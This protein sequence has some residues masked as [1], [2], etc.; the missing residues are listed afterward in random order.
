MRK[1]IGGGL[2]VSEG[3]Y[4]KPGAFSWR[5][6]FTP[7]LTLR[8]LHKLALLLSLVSCLL[9]SAYAQDTGGVKGRVRS[10]RGDTIAGATVTARRDSKEIRTAT[11]DQKGE[12][13]LTGLDP[14]TYNFAFDAKGYATGVKYGVEIKKGKIKDLGDRLYLQVDQGT[15]V[16]VRGSVF[17]KDGRSVTAAKVELVRLDD[18]GTRKIAT[19]YTNYLGEFGFSQ[20]EGKATYRVTAKY[21]DSTATKDIEV[22]SAMV[23]RIAVRLDINKE[24]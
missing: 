5:P 19:T 3:V 1:I 20:P 11:S 4:I 15:R 21:K 17:F 12:F 14:G 8:L 7:S 10:M 9:S 16:I 2:S 23:Y 13:R 24:N 6:L 18:T 22:D